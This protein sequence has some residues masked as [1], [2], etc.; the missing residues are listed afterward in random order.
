LHLD[1]VYCFPDRPPAEQLVI[2]DCIEFNERFRYADPVADLAF[3]V[4]DL[5]FH[6]R[7][8][9]AQ[10]LADAYFQARSD[11]EG[12]GLLP[13]YIAYRAAVRG[14]VEGFEL[15]EPE[16]PEEERSAAWLRARAHWLLALGEL[17]PPEHRPC[18]LLVAGLPGTGKSTLA[19]RLAEQAGFTVLRSDVIR[20][21]LMPEADRET[22]Y[23][24]Q[25]SER[26]YAECLRQA[27]ELLFD[28]RR[29]LIDANFREENKRRL[30][31]DLAARMAVPLGLL[32]CRARPETVRARLEARRGD[33]SDADYGVH[34]LLTREWEEP[35]PAN[36]PRLAVI[37]TD[38]GAEASLALALGHLRKM[39]LTS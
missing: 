5:K 14:K 15:R 34:A 39:G 26:T 24:P 32:V 1:H 9:L 23:S 6:G 17:E 13:F 38:G 20:K 29:V 11:D 22:L 4:M 19:A 37:E 35:E 25:A 12:R 28:G 2:I 33:A 30:F 7:P 21:Q 36:Y 18:L 31:V 3:L 16:V 10:P 8:D 27:A